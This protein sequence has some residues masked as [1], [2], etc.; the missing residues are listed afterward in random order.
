MNL[1]SSTYSSISLFLLDT[2]PIH[3]LITP[4]VDNFK[5]SVD[6]M[7]VLGLCYSVECYFKYDLI[8][9]E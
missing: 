6:D 7:D 4:V 1:Y 8:V 5:L 3:L 2:R 9:Y